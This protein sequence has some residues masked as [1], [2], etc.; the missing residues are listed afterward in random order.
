MFLEALVFAI[1]LG[2]ILK[3]SI[4]NLDASKIPGLYLIFIAFFIEFG[5]VMGIRSG[6]LTRGIVTYILDLIM[7]GLLILFIYYN[8]RN[9]YILMMAFGLFLN[10]I[11]IFANGGAMP[12]D[13]KATVTAGLYPSIKEAKVLIAK[14]GLYRIIDEN[15]KL[16]FL[17]DIIPKTFLRRVALSIGDA[18]IGVGLILFIVTGMRK[19][20]A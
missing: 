9:P 18:I 6:I 16:W 5:I 13:A 20:S 14:E 2:Y 17:G 11:A 19:K 4:K 7:Y 8:R 3:G 10:S 15:T 1:I 12:V